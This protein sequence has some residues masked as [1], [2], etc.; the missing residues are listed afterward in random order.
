[1]VCLVVQCI[2]NIILTYVVL[3]LVHLHGYS[4]CIL[5]WIV[6]LFNCSLSLVKR[7]AVTSAVHE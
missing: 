1:M 2:S 4:D 6:S 3:L 5:G 7:I